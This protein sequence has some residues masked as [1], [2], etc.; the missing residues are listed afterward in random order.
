MTCSRSLSFILSLY[1]LLILTHTIID[2]SS[3]LKTS[4]HP[5]TSS[6]T[7]C[8]S[9]VQRLLSLCLSLSLSVSLSVSVSLSLLALATKMS[10]PAP[11]TGDL[12]SL[13]DALPLLKSIKLLRLVSALCA[14]VELWLVERK[15]ILKPGKVK[16]QGKGGQIHFVLLPS[17]QRYSVHLL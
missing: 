16:V 13:Q 11:K 15:H 9:S 2:Y 6:R 1:S 17:L 5:K 14:C 12:G 4:V 8:P 3:W 10:C 7:F